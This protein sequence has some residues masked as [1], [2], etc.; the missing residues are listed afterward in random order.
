MDVNKVNHLIIK[1]FNN[2]IETDSKLKWLNL[3]LN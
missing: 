2:I 3:N 1:E